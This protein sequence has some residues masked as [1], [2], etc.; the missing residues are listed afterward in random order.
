MTRHALSPVFDGAVV[1][2]GFCSVLSRSSHELIFFG[3][4]EP[5]LPARHP[6]D[7][8]HGLVPDA[9]RPH[10]RWDRDRSRH[11][12]PGFPGGQSPTPIQA[13]AVWFLGTFACQLL[14]NK[15]RPTK[16]FNIGLGGLAGG[17][18]LFVIDATRGATRITPASC[19]PRG[20]APPSTSSSTSRVSA[21]SLSLEEGLSIVAGLR[22]TGALGA[23]V[24]FLGIASLGYLAALVVRELPPWSALLLA[25]PISTIMVASR[26][27]SRGSEHARRL[28]ILL[29]TAVRVQ[30][31]TR[32]RLP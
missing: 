4:R 26:A 32:P 29:D 12:C 6:A 11:L 24:A 19:W 21:V 31:V 1:A 22:P 28:K 27:Q 2:V 3:G 20:S 7:H 14:S 17:L 10:R 18:A 25:V 30:T 15:R 9:D 16:L 13:L 8:A 5:D 23:L